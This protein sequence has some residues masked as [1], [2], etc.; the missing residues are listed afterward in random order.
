MATIKIADLPQDAETTEAELKSVSGGTINP[1]WTRWPNIGAVIGQYGGGRMA[2]SCTH[3]AP[4]GARDTQPSML[5][6]RKM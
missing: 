3:S 2:P 1:Y 5:I 4:E 6:S